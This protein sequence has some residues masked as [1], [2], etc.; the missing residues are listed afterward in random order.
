MKFIELLEILKSYPGDLTAY[1]LEIKNAY[2]NMYHI[3]LILSTRYQHLQV[4][5]LT[6]KDEKRLL[7]KQISAITQTL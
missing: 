5:L 1:L 3:G 2:E 4:D 6:L 7:E